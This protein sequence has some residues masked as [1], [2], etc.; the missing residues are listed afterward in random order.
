MEKTKKLKVTL[1]IEKDSINGQF[2]HLQ[3][4]LA[5]EVKA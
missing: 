5:L 2:S 3:V 4:V 1:I